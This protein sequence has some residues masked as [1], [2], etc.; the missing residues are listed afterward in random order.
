MKK[1]VREIL[2]KPVQF[3]RLLASKAVWSVQNVEIRDSHSFYFFESH[4]RLLTATLPFAVLFGFAAGGVVAG[5]RRRLTIWPFVSL[6]VLFE[7]TLIL[8]LVGSRYR[9]PIVPFLAVL[10][11]LGVASLID[12]ARARRPAFAALATIVLLSG[13]L[14]LVRDHRPSRNL[15]EEW[16]LT[17]EAL[18]VEGRHAEARDAFQLALREDP[19]WV[20]ALV[21][22]AVLEHAG[23]NIRAAERLLDR[24]I[25]IDDRYP[26]SHEIR[27]DLARERR[28]FDAAIHHYREAVRLAPN[29]AEARTK[30]AEV[31]V[32]TG[33]VSEAEEAYVQVLD[34]FERKLIVIPDADR[35]RVWL[36][37]AELRGASGRP[38]AA[39][40]AAERSLAI[41]PA[42]GRGWILLSMLALDAGEFSRAR[43]AYHRATTLV[44]GDPLLRLLRTRLNSDGA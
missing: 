31:L 43:D 9:L 11:G 6:C 10:G 7:A 16:E 44:P 12:L 3:L 4:S 40:E 33:N 32:A 17:G 1:A 14:T 20:R 18:V 2:A 23:G 29:D 39:I 21:G 27:G 34:L 25:R 28:D 24:A 41:E 38:L 35:A 36:R 37:L 15:A 19:R 22:L 5:V 26:Q 8:L 13:L 30:L 42:N